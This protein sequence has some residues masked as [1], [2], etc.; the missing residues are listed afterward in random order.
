M[1]IKIV[2]SVVDDCI[3]PRRSVDSY[4]RSVIVA[5]IKI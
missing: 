5:A 4:E 3:N 1:Y 2:W